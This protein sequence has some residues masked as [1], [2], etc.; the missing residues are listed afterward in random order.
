[1][2]KLGIPGRRQRHPRLLLHRPGRR[3]PRGVALTLWQPAR[4][5]RLEKFLVAVLASISDATVQE[6]RERHLSSHR[7]SAQHLG[8]K[9]DYRLYHL[10]HLRSL[11]RCRKLASGIQG[12]VGHTM[13]SFQLFGLFVRDGLSFYS[14]KLGKAVWGVT[15]VAN[16]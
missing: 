7:P 15:R 11:T 16:D 8:I 14:T 3:Q 10:P 4:G 2:G 12:F 6:L 1:M 5:M 9:Y 13:V